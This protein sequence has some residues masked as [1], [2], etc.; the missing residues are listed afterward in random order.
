MFHFNQKI[1]P[2]RTLLCLSLLAFT[3]AAASAAEPIDDGSLKATATASKNYH[4]RR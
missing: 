1:R 3:G 2:V 4:R